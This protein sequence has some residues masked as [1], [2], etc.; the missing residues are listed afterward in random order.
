M[1]FEIAPKTL[2]RYVDYSHAQFG[3]R[4]NATE[5]L[6]VF[7]NQ[8]QQIQYTIE[9]ENEHKELNFLDVTIKNNLNESYNLKVY[10]KPAI[11]NVQ[12]KPRSSICLSYGGI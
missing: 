5:V 1:R 2:H 12:V 10:R 9:F 8:D 11:P 7:N 3:D 6:N 4:S